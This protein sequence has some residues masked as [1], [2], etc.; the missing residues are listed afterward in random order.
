MKTKVTYKKQVKTKIKTA[1]F[2]YL[3]NKQQKHSKVK[4]IRYTNLSTQ[5]YIINP[6][7]KNEEVNLLY[8]LRS[9]GTDCK[10]NVK[11]NIYT[12]TSCVFFVKIKKTVNNMY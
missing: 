7:F 8:A 11:Q 2:V 4:D 1:A 12:Q 10:V 5:K 6:L 9:R 3:K